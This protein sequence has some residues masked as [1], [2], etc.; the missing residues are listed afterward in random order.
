M[1]LLCR[2]YRLEG[3]AFL[4]IIYKPNVWITNQA[5]QAT[6]PGSTN[7]P[8][9][10][11]MSLGTGY[12]ITCIFVWEFALQNGLWNKNLIDIMIHIYSVI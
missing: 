10:E 9:H 11:G 8:H 1:C 4:T 7:T 12:F 2:Q 3:I 5:K 6:T